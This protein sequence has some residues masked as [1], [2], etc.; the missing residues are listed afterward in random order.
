MTADPTRI[1]RDLEQRDI[2]LFAS[3]EPMTLGVAQTDLLDN[4]TLVSDNL[5]LCKDSARQT[6]LV[7]SRNCSMRSSDEAR[8][9]SSSAGAAL[10][11]GLSPLERPT[12]NGSRRSSA[13]IRPTR[14]GLPSSPSFVLHWRSRTV[15]GTA[16]PRHH[17]ARRGRA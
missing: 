13:P 14:T 1:E 3:D 10:S 17:G 8:A 5:I 11:R 16:D 9:S 12:A 2:A 7:A 15:P 4:A 6:P